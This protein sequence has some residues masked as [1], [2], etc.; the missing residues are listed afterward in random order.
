MKACAKIDALSIL[1]LN[2]LIDRQTNRLIWK[3]NPAAKCPSSKKKEEE[4]NG[5]EWK[6]SRC[7]VSLGLILGWLIVDQLPQI[8]AQISDK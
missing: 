3:T 7:Q 4:R 8:P 1:N 5:E 2:L 6:F